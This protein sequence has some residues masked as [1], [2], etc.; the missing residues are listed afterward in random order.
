MKRNLD[1]TTDLLQLLS[2]G[3][4]LRLLSLLAEQELSVAELTQVTGLTQS[5]VSTHLGKLKDA[6]LLLDRRVGTSTF[7]RLNQSAMPADASK[8]WTLLSSQLADAV[9]DQDRHRA[10]AAVRARDEGG[11]WH[12]R[13]AGEMERHYSPGRTWEAVAQ[14]FPGL[15]CLGKV[16]DVGSGD[17]AIGLM[18][19]PHASRYVCFD[20]SQ[21]VL[22][23][24]QRRLSKHSHVRCVRGDMQALPYASESFDQVLM[25]NVLT[26]ATAPTRAISEAAR[27]LAPRGRLCLVTL[28]QHK[29]M[30][31]TASYHHVQPG[32]SPASLATMLRSAKLDVSRCEA[33]SRERKY[34]HF[35]VITAFAEKS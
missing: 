17:G 23:A 33:T 14:A 21:R 11:R 24:A 31:I 27:V 6:Q 30:D 20:Q 28:D 35:Q 3:T 26:Y 9:L 16:L 34:P 7:Y 12:E 25:F 2:E 19:A 15:M 22:T 18:L 13:V 1:A 5:R 8:L 10:L 4:R 32:F 29:H